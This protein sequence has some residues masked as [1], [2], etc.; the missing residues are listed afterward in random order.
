MHLDAPNLSFYET[1]SPQYQ[2]ILLVSKPQKITEETFPDGKQYLVDAKVNMILRAVKSCGFHSK[3]RV[4]KV[5]RANKWTFKLEFWGWSFE[6]QSKTLRIINYDSQ[7]I[8]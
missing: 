8:F 2:T 4:Q 3:P 1:R 7:S 5:T 6:K